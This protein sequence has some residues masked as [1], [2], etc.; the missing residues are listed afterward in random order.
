M[1]A[2]VRL[3]IQIL[4]QKAHRTTPSG[5]WGWAGS[6]KKS[7]FSLNI[8]G[9]NWCCLNCLPRAGFF[10]FSIKVFLFFNGVNNTGLIQELNKLMHI[11]C[12]T[13]HLAQSK[14]ST[15]YHSICGTGGNFHRSQCFKPSAVYA[16]AP[17]PPTASGPALAKGAWLGMLSCIPAFCR[18]PCLG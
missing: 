9:Y 6:R 16:P 11:K 13:Q 8:I 4:H 17:P 14:Y 2:C 18:R 5:V 3:D 1:R 7:Y 12:L 10:F 15:S